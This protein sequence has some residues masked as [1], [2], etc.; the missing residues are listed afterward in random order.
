[1]G[2]QKPGMRIGLLPTLLARVPNLQQT[3]AGAAFCF[4]G[5][6]VRV[7]AF[8][9]AASAVGG[10]SQQ[11]FIAQVV[12]FFCVLLRPVANHEGRRP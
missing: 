11:L 1:M 8:P 6:P 12:K 2:C 4:Q 5:Q 3:K 9:F 7:T 10:R